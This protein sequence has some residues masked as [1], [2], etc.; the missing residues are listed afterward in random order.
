MLFN[1][2]KRKQEGS[3]VRL[4]GSCEKNI[5]GGAANL[6]ELPPKGFKAVTDQQEQRNGLNQEPLAPEAPVAT[7]NGSDCI[8]INR[9]SLRHNTKRSLPFF[10]RSND[11]NQVRKGDLGVRNKERGDE[12]MDFPTAGAL[13]AAD[14]QRK[15]AI[16]LLQVSGIVT[17]DGKTA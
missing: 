5:G 2:Y 12:K 4:C 8:F 13:Y 17:M 11:L 10:P 1:Q 7:Q 9:R 3:P 16:S 6:Q 14:T 15:E